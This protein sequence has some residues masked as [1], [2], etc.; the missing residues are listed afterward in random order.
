MLLNGE[1]KTKGVIA[2]ECLTTQERENYL[3][4][5]KEQGLLRRL[6]IIER[7]IK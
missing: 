5:L 2:P 7:E 6:E 4:I 1:I 3:D